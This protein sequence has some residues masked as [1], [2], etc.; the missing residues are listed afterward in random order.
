MLN[1]PSAA[2]GSPPESWGVAGQAGGYVLSKFA[3][4]SGLDALSATVRRVTARFH[5][6]RLAFHSLAGAVVAVAGVVVLFLR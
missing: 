5:H 2:P 6:E 1:E 3:L 4:A